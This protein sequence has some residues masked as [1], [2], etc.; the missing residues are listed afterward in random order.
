MFMRSQ[1]FGLVSLATVLTW[2]GM[3]HGQ[4]K[5]DGQKKENAPT[6]MPAV[7][8]HDQFERTHD[9]AKLQGDVVVMIYGDRKSAA[10]CQT[11]GDRI[12]VHFHPAA[13]G[14]P[15]FTTSPAPVRPVAYWSGQTPAP[16]VKV[17]LVAV[18]GK[19]SSLFRTHTRTQVAHD[20]PAVTFWIDFQ[21]QLPKQHGFKEGVPNLFVVDTLGRFRGTLSGNL[22]ADQ[23]GGLVETI[24][25]IRAEAR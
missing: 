13:Q 23:F 25:R 18:V 6:P 21:D 12:Y 15:T 24:D 11:L 20:W 3:A 8:M 16:D 1:W 2:Q 4:K 7:V 9:L 14:M 19:T 22:D 5:E 10:A 17:A